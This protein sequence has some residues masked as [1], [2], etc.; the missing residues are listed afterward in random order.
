[1]ADMG[2]HETELSKTISSAEHDQRVEAVNYAQASVGLERS[3]LR[4]ADEE[5]VQRLINGDIC[6]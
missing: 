5:Y 4:A 2:P 6:L 3:S 1:M